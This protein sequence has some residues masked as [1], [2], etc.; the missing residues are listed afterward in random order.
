MLS[1]LS[2]TLA[3]LRDVLPQTLADTGALSLVASSI[4]K[5]V[6]SGALNKA[7]TSLTALQQSLNSLNGQAREIVHILSPQFEHQEEDSQMDEAR[8][9][10]D[11]LATQCASALEDLTYLCPWL[12]SENRDQVLQHFPELDQVPTLAALSQVTLG[13]Q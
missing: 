7:N 8:W 5:S 1:G 6:D 2:T 11:S 3:V 12:L 10:A 13:S 9:W 4:R